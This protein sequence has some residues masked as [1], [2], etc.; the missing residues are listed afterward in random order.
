MR[1]VRRTARR[2]VKARYFSGMN[3]NHDALTQAATYTRDDLAQLL[4]V[5][6]RHVANLDA[7]ER[8]P[9]KIRFGRAC[10]CLAQDFHLWLEAGSPARDRCEV[11][12]EVAHRWLIL[13]LTNGLL[14]LVEKGKQ[15]TRRASRYRC[16][17]V[18]WSD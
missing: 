8:L 5:S 2:L 12:R 11:N 1:S 9:K 10:P 15:R 4:K 18:M 6:L 14:E 13:L 17:R 7:S 16:R 3:T